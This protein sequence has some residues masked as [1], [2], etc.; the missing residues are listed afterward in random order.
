[1]LYRNFLILFPALFFQSAQISAET[2]I[3]C[4]ADAYK[5]ER[6]WFGLQQKVYFKLL[7]ISSG[8]TQFCKGGVLTFEGSL[9]VCSETIKTYVRVNPEITVAKVKKFNCPEGADEPNQPLFLFER[10]HSDFISV[11]YYGEKNPDQHFLEQG[12]S[13]IGPLMK[14]PA[15]QVKVN[16]GE[17]V[18]KDFPEAYPFIGLS[19]EK[20][21][22]LGRDYSIDTLYERLVFDDINHNY[23]R[24]SGSVFE[25]YVDF[26]LAYFDSLSWEID[27]KTDERISERT[28]KYSR[29]CKKLTER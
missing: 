17:W 28:T 18:T 25:T 8:W 10:M 13:Y 29:R 15:I 22:Y 26:G 19:T 3:D 11:S 16:Q 23:R 21:G 1:M 2:I 12:C 6:N 4:T 9:A 5:L 27:P 20:F 7:G 24:Q 14:I